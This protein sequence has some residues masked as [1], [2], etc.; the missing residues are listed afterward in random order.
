MI[1]QIVPTRLE[2]L[3]QKMAHMAVEL[4]TPEITMLQEKLVEHTTLIWDQIPF[5]N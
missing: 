2:Y 4:L 3:Q 1:L 5:W